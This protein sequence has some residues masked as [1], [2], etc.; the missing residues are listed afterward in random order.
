MIRGYDY[1][2]FD[3]RKIL[4]FYTYFYEM[5]DN[6]TF[7]Y[8]KAIIDFPPGIE[9]VLLDI[10]EV[11]DIYIQVFK[12]GILQSHGKGEGMTM[13]LNRYAEMLC[14]VSKTPVMKEITSNPDLKK[15]K[16]FCEKYDFDL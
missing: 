8:R 2:T 9:N 10:E 1:D 13:I 3:R 16:E 14:R 6:H 5:H 15:Y 11:P 7:P 12:S 4:P